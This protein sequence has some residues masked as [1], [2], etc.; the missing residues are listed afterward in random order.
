MVLVI[1]IIGVGMVLEWYSPLHNKG[2]GT[3]Q[4]KVVEF[5]VTVF[6]TSTQCSSTRCERHRRNTYCYIFLY[7]VTNIVRYCF[8]GSRRSTDTRRL[9][10]SSFIVTKTGS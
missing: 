8:F 10:A 1:I 7:V 4:C 3:W 9:R 2:I 5:V 6:L